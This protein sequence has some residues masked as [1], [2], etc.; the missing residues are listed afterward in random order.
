MQSFITRRKMIIIGSILIVGLIGAAVFN[1]IQ[2][3]QTTIFVRVVPLGATLHLD[4]SK[5]AL[6]NNQRHTVT[7]GS[8]KLSIHKDGFIDQTIEFTADGNRDA[9]TDVSAVLD[10]E[11]GNSSAKQELYSQ[12]NQR[13]VST[14][15]SLPGQLYQNL[16]KQAAPCQ[17][18]RYPHS[19]DIKALCIRQNG[20]TL[21]SELLQ[22][23]PLA[24]YSEVAS[25]ENG[26]DYMLYTT[27]QARI[28][29]QLGNE[30]SLGTTLFR[31]EYFDPNSFSADS[32]NKMISDQGYQPGQGYYY[33]KDPRFA[34]QYPQDEKL[35]SHFNV[36][37]QL[38]SAP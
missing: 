24:R 6:A 13:L 21:R 30:Q 4:G 29:Y 20:N 5:D 38:G 33:S 16:P 35:T 12:D 27:Q 1:Y 19:R 11:K 25:S 7:K 32:F 2:N 8:H 22:K 23:Y 18:P 14:I 3:M 34:S 17:S 15:N 37:S 28:F 26:I 36:I 9:V 10:P 31:V